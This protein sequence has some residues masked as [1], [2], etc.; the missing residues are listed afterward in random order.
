MGIVEKFSTG[1][2]VRR[3]EDERFVTGQGQYTDDVNIDGQVYMVVVRSPFAHAIIKSINTDDVKD[4]DGVLGVYTGAD[5]VAAGGA[6]KMPYAIVG[7]ESAKPDR[8]ILADGRVRFAGEPVAIIVAETQAQAEEASELIDVDYDILDA[9]TDIESAIAPD[10]PLVHDDAPGNIAFRWRGQGDDAQMEQILSEAE[11]VVEMRLENNRVIV[12]AMEPRAAVAHMDGDKLTVITST[13]GGWALKDRLSACLGLEKESV[14][15]VTPDV[16][17]G[18]GMKAFTY[19]EQYLA[20]FAAIQLGRPVKWLAGRGESMLSDNMGRD[21]ISNAK[22][23]LDKDHRITGIDIHSYAGMGAY[24]SQ[25]AQGIPTMLQEKILPGVYD[26]PASRF[27]VDGVFTNSTQ[28]DAYRGAGR[29]EGI[30]LLERLMDVAAKHVGMDPIEFRSLNFI[31]PEQM[32]YK[33][34]VGLTYD[35]GE[36]ENLMRAAL[37]KA[38]YD[39]LAKRQAASAAKGLRRDMGLCYYVECTLGAP[40]EDST[41]TFNPTG[42][43]EVTVGTQSN[44][45]GHETVYAQ[46]VHEQTGVPIEDIVI[47]QGDTDRIKNGG[48]TGG[49]RSLIAQAIAMRAAARALIEKA[50]D[51]AAEKL[52]CAP[53]DLSFDDGAFR[54]SGT[55]ISL[56][57]KTLAGGLPQGTLDVEAGHDDYTSTFP[58]GCHIAEVEVDEE[59]GVV[60]LENYVVVDDFGLLYNPLVVQG[61]VHGGIVQGL[62][63]ALMER[64][65]YDETGQLLTGSFMDYTVPRADTISDIDFTHM[66]VKSLN[67][68]MGIKGCGEAGTVGACAAVMNA[69]QRALDPLDVGFV[70]MPATPDRLWRQIRAAS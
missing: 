64:T 28:I 6:N 24:F 63:Q 68:E 27:R 15:V 26:I 62:G 48:G 69:I 36:F 50:Q 7:Q 47:V 44:G 8:T 13:Q 29:P 5:F 21:H 49:S 70:D 4:A 12:V 59:T 32:P 66:G 52:E 56:D 31:R 54:V 14:R 53:E 10:A 3:L 35:V 67:N 30:Y 60:T 20:P 41:F 1:A 22:L 61:Q 57:L 34:A 17:G 65:V 39:G 51:H 2:S 37:V 18:F 23:A 40:H 25:F 46:V 55:D 45:Q 11:T 38:D 58:N 9:V 19:P 43:L 42:Q 16:G 33:T